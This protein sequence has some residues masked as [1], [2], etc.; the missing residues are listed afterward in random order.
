[1]FEQRK[2]IRDFVNRLIEGFPESKNPKWRYILF[3]KDSI[4]GFAF[5]A[6]YLDKREFDTL[7]TAKAG[8]FWGR[9]GTAHL[10]MVLR[11]LTQQMMPHLF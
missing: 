8:G 4:N 7:P 11:S 6:P 2:N 9:A 3:F 5:S 1:M 10:A